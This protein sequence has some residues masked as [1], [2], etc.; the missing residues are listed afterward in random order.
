MNRLKC[1]TALA[2]V[3]V[4]LAPLPD[5]AA[6]TVRDTRSVATAE[7]GN[8]IRALIVPRREARLSSQVTARIVSIGPEPGTAFAK[9]KILVTFDCRSYRAEF[10]K[11]QAELL[12]T[13]KT[14]E[15]R[16]ELSRL[17]SGS[18]LELDLA[19]AEELRAR[20]A[21]D[22]VEATLSGCNIRAPYDGRVVSRLAN[23]H[24]SVTPGTALIEILD[25]RDLDA[26]IIVPSRWLSWLKTG[27][28]LEVRIEELD[29]IFAG[30]VRTIGSRVDPVS[31]SIEITAGLVGDITALKPGMSGIARFPEKRR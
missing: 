12:A 27:Q 23:A 29:R 17:Q 31:Q 21:L 20:A 26:R 9:G 19:R 16:K 24:E 28:V 1:L 22:A 5:A 13:S 25:E 7:S 30:R 15:N 11:A 4:V 2:L 18:L 6:Q 8:G 3:I 10:R 14:Y